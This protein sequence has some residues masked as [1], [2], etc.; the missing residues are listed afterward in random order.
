MLVEDTDSQIVEFMSNNLVRIR[1]NKDESSKIITIT[2]DEF[3]KAVLTAK[4][5]NPVVVKEI[6]DTPILPFNKHVRTIQHRKINDDVDYVIMLRDNVSCDI[7]YYDTVYANVGMPKMIF[8]FK[9]MNNTIVRGKVMAVKD[10]II[11][12]NTKMF[13]YPFSNASSQEGTIC[14]GENKVNSIDIKELSMLH[15]IPS[16]FL[17][18]PNSNHSYGSNKSNLEYR[19][20]LEKL[21]GTKFPNK[22]L[23]DT[24]LL[25]KDWRKSLR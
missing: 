10:D 9:V 25:Y 24:E 11:T 14:F 18:M 4:E 17:S 5:N 1:K 2:F 16:M 6:V 19:P 20:L 12:E 3:C 15:S 13:S 7:D 22:W 21:A 23:K 8:A